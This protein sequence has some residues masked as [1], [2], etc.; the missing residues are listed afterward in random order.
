MKVLL[1]GLAF[2]LA[3]AAQPASAQAIQIG[4]APPVDRT[5][6][7]R[8]EQHRPV[9]GRVTRFTA[10]RTIRFERAAD[11]YALHMMLRTL[12]SDAPGEGAAAWRAAL[13]PLVGI[14]LAF[15]L[16]GTGKIVALENSEAVAQA[17]EAALQ[18]AIAAA[19]EG[20]PGQR[21]A[22]NVLTLFSGLSPEG[23]QA[24]LSGELQPMLLFANSSIDATAGKG[25]R[26]MA[27]APLVRPVPVEGLL[28]VTAQTGDALTLEEKLA[29]EGT[30]VTILYHLSRASGLVETQERSLA[31]GALALTEN[32]TLMPSK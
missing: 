11:G 1:A 26:T 24:L 15:H 23:R 18:K 5:Y 30:Q 12:D 16:D 4:F 7:Y 28:R 27:G 9:E 25:L 2:L 21:G 14:D 22:R 29:G 8:I 13:E 19:A 6:D 20:S 32:R 3:I 31:A 10:T 17:I